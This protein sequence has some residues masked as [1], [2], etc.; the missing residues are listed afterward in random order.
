M[1]KYIIGFLL[2]FSFLAAQAQEVKFE[3]LKEINGTQLHVKVIGEGEPIIVVHGG[4]GLNHTYFLPHLETLAK[5]YQ[6]IFYDQRSSGQSTMNVKAH[7]TLQQFADDVDAIRKEFQIDKVNI[8]CHSWSSVFI[9]NYLALY[10]QNVK[11]VIFCSP[12]PLSREY[13]QMMTTSMLSKISKEDSIARAA[14]ISSEAFKKGDMQTVYDLMRLNFKTV[15]CDTAHISLFD[16]KLQE[17]Y[18]VASLSFYGFMNELKTYNF[19]DQLKGA[20]YP[21]LVIH[22]DCDIIPLAA[23]EHLKS[24]FPN[25]QL[26]VFHNSGHYPFI[27]ENKLFTKTVSRFLKRVK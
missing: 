25:S 6:L 13:D 21:V 7:M 9:A 26:A 17:N 10:P 1:Y 11:S 20:T 18:L 3:G 16:V 4:P 14:I 22:G 27:E 24:M 12:T 8:L 15:F 19:Y 23:D 5:K 2:S